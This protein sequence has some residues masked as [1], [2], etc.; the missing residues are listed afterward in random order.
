[1]DKIN[2]LEIYENDMDMYLHE[3][4]GEND[5]DD[6]IRAASQNVWN[7][8]LRYICKKLFRGTRAL[9][10]NNGS[11]NEYNYKLLIYIADYY[12]DICSYYDKEC[13]I[14][15]FSYLTNIDKDTIYL[16]S[17]DKDV[18]SSR[19]SIYK[20]LTAA[21]EESLSAKLAT[22]NKNPVGIIAILNHH[23]A[24]GREAQAPT[25][26]AEALTA[27]NLP[28]LSAIERHNDGGTE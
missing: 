14:V 23:F 20:K 26:Q 17:N 12:M 8:C 24:W 11:H 6:Y 7:G 9:K 15:G 22:G 27:D 2:N 18:T 3:F 5:N 19:L 13:S 21:R 16:W 1:M 28:R 4:F 10:D 25:K